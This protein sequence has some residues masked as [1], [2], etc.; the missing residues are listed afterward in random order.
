MG[1]GGRGGGGVA[2]LSQLPTTMHATRV[3][4]RRGGSEAKGRGGAQE[5]GMG[6]GDRGSVGAAKFPQ[7]L[8]PHLPHPSCPFPYLRCVVKTLTS[9]PP[10]SPPSCSNLL[11]LANAYISTHT[12]LTR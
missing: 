9:S 2:A 4:E 3:L 5:D 1:A 8:G 11:S 10:A 12:H 7:N 6:G